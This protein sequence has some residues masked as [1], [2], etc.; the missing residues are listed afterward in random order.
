MI[1]ENHEVDAEVFI[2]YDYAEVWSAVVTA[3][4]VEVYFHDLVVI[5]F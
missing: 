5:G 1:V 2:V 4:L 3:P